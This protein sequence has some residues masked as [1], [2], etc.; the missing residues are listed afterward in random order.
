[1]LQPIILILILAA[2]GF[3]VYRVV[4][5]YRAAEGTTWER[6]LATAKGSATVLWSYIVMAGGTLM[7]WS[8][9]V[10][11]AFNLPDVRTWIQGHLT[12]EMFG[13]A[14][15]TVALVSFWARLRTL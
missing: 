14:L 13:I 3:A 9:N 4:K 5:R 15:V 6:V 8:V 2:I 10:A 11:D 12:A 7:G 1:M